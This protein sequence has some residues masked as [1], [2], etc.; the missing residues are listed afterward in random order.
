MISAIS[1]FRQDSMD[2]D[3]N[4]P[5]SGKD[6]KKRVGPGEGF[7]GKKQRLINQAKVDIGIPAQPRR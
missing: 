4:C 5:V 6:K 3:E 7:S 1:E 2:L